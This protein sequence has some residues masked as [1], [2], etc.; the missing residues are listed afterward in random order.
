MGLIWC[1][2]ASIA[3]VV[4]SV[5]S[6]EK[7]SPE[8]MACDKGTQKEDSMPPYTMSRFTISILR[9]LARG[10]NPNTVVMVV[11]ITGRKR[12]APVRTI[13]CT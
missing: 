13:S 5:S 12:C 4:T 10:N 1:G 9:L 7:V 6:V 11:N 2:R 8:T 3:G